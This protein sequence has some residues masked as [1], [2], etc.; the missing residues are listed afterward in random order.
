MGANA[1]NSIGIHVKANLNLGNS[2]RSWGNSLKVELSQKTIRL[3]HASLSLKDLNVDG[4]LVVCIGREDLRFFDGNRGS[5]LDQ[6]RHNPTR[7][8]DS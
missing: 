1:Q 7:C 8:F 6:S 2:S 3:G 4:R 5:P